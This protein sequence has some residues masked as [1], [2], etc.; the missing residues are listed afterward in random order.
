MLQKSQIEQF[1]KDVESVRDIKKLNAVIA[2]ATGYSSGNVSEYLNG[3]KDPSESF[4]NSFYEWF[5]N[6]PRE[7][8]ASEPPASYLE[9]RRDQKNNSTK[10]DVPVFGGFTTLGNIQVYDDGNV[11]NKIVGHLPADF[12]P[13]CD[14]AERAK[15]DS[16]YPLIMNQ[17][18]LIGKTCPVNG[19]VWGEKYII[20][21]T[22]GKDVTKFVH[23]GVEPGTIKLKAYNK[24][25]PDQE[26]EIK[27]VVFA[28]RVHW[29]VNPT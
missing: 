10:K 8:K 1:Y 28:C 24:N 14:Y 15:G 19:I 26:V 6:V 5:E 23:P 4:L 20:K 9:K 27:E 7:S 2:R 22:D 17:A 13:N 16:M 3:K 25:I 29:I 11:K 21:T 18:L 12:F